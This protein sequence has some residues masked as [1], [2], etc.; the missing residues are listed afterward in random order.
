MPHFENSEYFDVLDLLID[1]PSSVAALY[2]A[3]VRHKGYNRQRLDLGTLKRDLEE[4]EREGWLIAAR[5]SESGMFS[6]VGNHDREAAF[7][8]YASWLPTADLDDL[9]L[10]EI[11]L[12]YELTDKGRGEW[13]RRA[14]I[15]PEELERAWTID[16]VPSHG[17]V[18]VRAKTEALAN[19]ALQQWLT[20]NPHL[21]LDPSSTL[22]SREPTFRLS[23]GTLVRDGVRI[24]Q[25]VMNQNNTA[26]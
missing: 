2:A 5:M 26:E 12:W 24:E 25:H 13:R 11:G 4:M 3:L 1:G 16:E 6:A 10:D 23:N 19:E 7:R 17:V 14:P 8:R 22:I 15:C 18:V 9:A 20:L 21:R